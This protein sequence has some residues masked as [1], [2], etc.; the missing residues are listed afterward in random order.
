MRQIEYMNKDDYY[1][2][3][4]RNNRVRILNKIK[5]NRPLLHVALFL[6]TVLTTYLVSGIYYS[7][8]IVSILLAHEMGHYLMCRK[9]GISATL[10]FFIP[11]PF[12]PFGTMGA[13]IKIRREV[14]CLLI[15]ILKKLAGNL[16]HP[17]FRIPHSRCRIP[18]NRAEV[19]L[20]GNQRIS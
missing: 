3:N 13:F 19:A 10:P 7:L 15:Y 8:S 12:Q 18:V 17:G 16:G 20:S 11:V 6:L 4:Q 2:Y 5:G 14:H 1:Y 9:Y